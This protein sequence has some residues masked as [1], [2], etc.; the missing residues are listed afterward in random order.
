MDEKWAG[1]V[2]STLT[3]HKSDNI[4]PSHIEFIINPANE[5]QLSDW[6]LSYS[7]KTKLAIES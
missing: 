2:P 6:E 5:T 3:N 1:L 4:S 7:L